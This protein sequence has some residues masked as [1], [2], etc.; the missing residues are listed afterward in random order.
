M[1]KL[2]V[3]GS[4]LCVTISLCLSGLSHGWSSGSKNGPGRFNW[5]RKAFSQEKGAVGNIQKEVFP[6]SSPP[7]LAIITDRDAC[8]SEIK[9]QAALK[10]LYAAVSTGQV[11]LVSVRVNVMSSDKDLGRRVVEL[12]RQL[13]N[14]SDEHSF[15][16]V[17]SSDW[18]SAAV[19]VKAH[20]VHV[21]EMHRRGTTDWNVG[22]QCGI[23]GIRL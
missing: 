9:L 19:E 7:Y 5:A 14:W 20:G 4:I 23:G 21:K 15:Q 6:L 18:V 22:A 11:D 3:I 8:D 16:V 17:V 2:R 10:A 12:T 13:M 1:A